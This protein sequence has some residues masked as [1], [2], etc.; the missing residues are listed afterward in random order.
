[1]AL[2][3]AN[4]LVFLW[5]LG[6]PPDTLEGFI[7]A[8]GLVPADFTWLTV[9]TS[10][11]VHGGL[12]HAA[13]NML[14]LWIFGDNVEDRM[15]HGRFLVFYLLSGIGAALAQTWAAPTSDVPMVG[16]SGA[17][18]GVMGAYFILYPR[19]RVLTLLPFPIM[20]IEIPAVYFLGLWFL[21]Q[22][23]NG[24]ATLGA[25]ADGRLAGGVAFCARGRLRGRRG[26]GVRLPAARAAARRVV[27]SGLAALIVRLRAAPARWTSA[28]SHGRAR[29]NAA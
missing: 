8:F 2:I 27:G 19:S 22:F 4:S 6:L 21:M 16:A 7:H 23:V 1:M 12:L 28:A 18:A 15:G 26:A 20:L 24:M 5:Q 11:F 3:M 10:M 25:A 13:G 17:I 9:F 14:Y 29:S